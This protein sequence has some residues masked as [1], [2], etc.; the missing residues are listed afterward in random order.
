MSIKRLHLGS[1]PK[2][3]RVAQIG[4]QCDQATAILAAQE[5]RGSTLRRPVGA[6][7][8]PVSKRWLATYAGHALGTDVPVWEALSAH[9]PRPLTAVVAYTERLIET[10]FPQVQRRDGERTNQYYMTTWCM[11]TCTLTMEVLFNP[12]PD[13]QRRLLLL[14]EQ[15][16]TQLASVQ[17]A[18]R[19]DPADMVWTW[20]WAPDDYGR[21]AEMWRGAAVPA[22][23][24]T[25]TRQPE[26]RVDEFVASALA[27][28]AQNDCL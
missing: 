11:G 8:A 5:M 2:R 21:G 25:L 26:H 23:T 10:N 12:A 16:S 7:I 24:P 13:Q 17:L 6:A 18:L 14:F 20:R 3:Q 19:P 9:L 27:G 22:G 28:A 4:E 1:Q 15:F